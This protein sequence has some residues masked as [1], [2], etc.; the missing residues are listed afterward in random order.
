M[1][2]K[3]NGSTNRIDASEKDREEGRQDE[4]SLRRPKPPA[5]VRAGWPGPAR[6]K[7]MGDTTRRVSGR[8][9]SHITS[10]CPVFFIET[11]RAA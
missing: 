4:R 6:A 7:V 9:N 5:G 1:R 8:P 3:G 2:F 10:A 11:S